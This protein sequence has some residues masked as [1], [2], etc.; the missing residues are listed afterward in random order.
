MGTYE[1]K[2]L[3]VTIHYP[4]TWT[5]KKDVDYDLHLTPTQPGGGGERSIT[6]DAPDIPSIPVFGIPMGMVESGYIDDIRKKHPGLVVEKAVDHKVEGA[7]KAR[8]VHLFWKRDGTP[9]QSL[10]LLIVKGDH[11]FILSADADEPAWA[12]TKADMDLI[13]ASIVWSK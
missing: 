1:D 3:G 9:H 4:S 11:V 6:F 8:L 10:S 13:V 7:K 2:K 5:A 12:A